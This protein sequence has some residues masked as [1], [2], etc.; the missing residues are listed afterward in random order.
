MRRPLRNTR[1]QVRTGLIIKFIK[2]SGNLLHVLQE[3]HFKELGVALVGERALLL[4]ETAK[5]YR[6]AVQK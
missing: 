4:Q 3:E 1:S 6:G 2:K 5:L